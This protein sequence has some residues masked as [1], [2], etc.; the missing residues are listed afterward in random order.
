[1]SERVVGYFLLVV[2]VIVILFSA[3][4]VYNAFIKKSLPINFFDLQG[5]T[6]QA[7]K[8]VGIPEME[9]LPKSSINGVVNLVAYLALMSFMGG[10]GYKIASLG[11]GLLRPIV[12]KSKNP[13]LSA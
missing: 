6:L 10:V 7:D 11:V 2:G 3:I 8:Q 1:M 4:S 9:I 13:P 5:V 12:V